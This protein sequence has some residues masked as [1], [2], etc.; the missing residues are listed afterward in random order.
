MIHIDIHVLVSLK[1]CVLY[2]YIYSLTYIH[3]ERETD[4][5]FPMV[6]LEFFSDIT[7]PVAI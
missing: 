2:I 3:I 4:V 6:S 7:L 5:R 1:T